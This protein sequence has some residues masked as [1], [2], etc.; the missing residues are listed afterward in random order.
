MLSEDQF[1]ILT[2]LHKRNNAH[3]SQRTLSR[4]TGISLGKVNALISGL[5]EEGLL[6]ESF[7]VTAK[8]RTALRPYRV[9]NA[10]IM[11]AGMSTRFAPLSYEKPKALLR[12][13]GDILIEREIRQL[14]EAGIDDITV[15]V[16]YLKEKLFYLADKFKVKIVVNE[17]YYRFNNPSSLILVTDRLKN[18]YICSSDD[19]F[20]ENVFEPYVYRSYYAAVF[21]PGKTDEYCLKTDRNGLIKQVS[22]GGTASWYMLGHVYFSNEFSEKFRQILKAEYDSPET[23]SSSGKISTCATFRSSRFISGN[24]TTS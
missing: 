11:A 10:V 17:D 18:T 5:K 9:D 19:Y 4:L 23:R 6:D 7:A 14:K 2:R 12:V 16:G 13:K 8:G 1:K 22:V 3:P 21:A 24:M 15:V 20:V